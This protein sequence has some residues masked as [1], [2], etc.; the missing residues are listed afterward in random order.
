MKSRDAS[1]RSSRPESG[2]ESTGLPATVISARIWPSPGVSISS[3]SADD[4]ELAEELGQ[5]AHPAVP[6]TEAHAPPDAGRRAGLRGA[7]VRAPGRG[8]G[9]H[10]ATLPVEVARERVHHVDEPRRERAEL[11]G[12][13]ADP[14]V[15]R[16]PLGGREVARDAPDRLGVDAADGRDDLGREVARQPRDLVEPVDVPVGVAELHEPFGD[17]R[18]HEPEQEVR[19]GA[20]A[21]EE[22]LVRLLRGLRA[23][24]VDDDEP[25]AARA[26]RAQPSGDVGHRHEAA[27]RRER[28]RAEDQQVV[29]AVE[30][31][32]RN[33]QR[34]RR[35]SARR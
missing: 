2:V 27:V 19:V 35:T 31:G 4:R 20:R 33:G 17:E 11:L 7:G 24:R 1:A 9:E 25:A 29:G 13:G 22:V 32:D 15:H 21:D 16:G 12:A 5:P 26:D 8:Q 28:V 3:A 30:V 10:R 14:P 23:A 6:A 18:V 34:A